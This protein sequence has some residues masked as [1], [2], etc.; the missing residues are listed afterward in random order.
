[1]R[2]TRKPLAHKDNRFQPRIAGS[3]RERR[4][5]L[6]HV[7]LNRRTVINARHSPQGFG[8]LLGVVHIGHEDCRSQAMEPLTSCVA[9]VNER[10]YRPVLFE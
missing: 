7:R 4:R 2:G 5:R 8:H 3:Y 9:P 10:S 6:D 1:M